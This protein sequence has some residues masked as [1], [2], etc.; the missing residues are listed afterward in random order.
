M[1]YYLKGK[2]DDLGD[3]FLILESG[4][5]GY[6]VFCAPK[7]LNGAS[8]SQEVKIFTYLYLRE[9]SAELYG[10]LNKEELD[11]FDTLNSISGIGP[12]TALLLASVGSLQKLKD[13]IETGKLPPEVKGIGQKRMQK[14]LLELT[15]KIAEIKKQSADTS[16][17][18]ALD[19]LISLGFPQQK[20]REVLISLPKEIVDTQKRIKEALRVL[21]RK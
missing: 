21:G 10:F 7:M 13:I 16:P 4:G 2:I 9:D 15:G 1:I 8:I 5:I 12:K 20:A 18:E 11:L 14:I 19:A 3:K 6:K 17:D